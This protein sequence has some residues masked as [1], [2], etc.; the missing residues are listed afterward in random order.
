MLSGFRSVW[1][2]FIGVALLQLGHGLQGS[3]IGILAANA[4]FS[5]TVTG[6]VMSGFSIGI[7]LSSAVSP[8]I[9]AA[10][11][12]IRV[13]AAFASIVSTAVLLIPV[14]VN[15]VWWFAMRLIGGI[16]MAGLAIVSES[17]L[18]AA[19]DNENRGK[20]LSLYMV[21]TYA[22]V[23]SGSFLLN[24]TDPSGFVRFIVVSALISLALVPISLAPAE[25][26]AIEQPR[27]VSLKDI[28][29]ASPLAFI[30]TLAVGL[31]QSAF[32]AMGALYGIMSSLSVGYVSIM[33]A[34][35]PIGVIIS[36][37]PVGMLSD[38]FDRRLVLMVLAVLSTALALV[39][40]FVASI[41]PASLIGLFTLFGAVSFPIYSLALAHA[42]DYLDKD[43]MLGASSKL[44]LLYGAGAIAGP[45]L[46]G[47]IMQYYGAG[48]FMMF[49][50][51]VYGM[52]GLFAIYRMFR[53]P[54]TPEETSDLIQVAPVTTPV[55]AAVI[56]EEHYET[57]EDN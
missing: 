27:P 8:R 9:V 10:V 14:W 7:L 19:A 44:V 36:Q 23:G 49:M 11:G 50:I 13:F 42:N 4:N 57:S 15:P 43:Q 32:F 2:L 41:S 40:L 1:A 5:A 33:M 6:I 38:R 54:E 25:A 21:I 37:Y 35:P 53:R 47:N 52:L 56:A 34:L 30:G 51:A 22:A 24:V 39:T 29:T 45:F 3:L 28:Y 31:G 48:G 26:P 18:N 46:A 20:M 17:W 12:H 55:A 16:G